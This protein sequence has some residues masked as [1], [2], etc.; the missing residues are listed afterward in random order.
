MDDFTTAI[1]VLLGLFSGMFV[2]LP[3]MIKLSNFLDKPE[4]PQTYEEFLYLRDVLE[5]LLDRKE[6]SF[7]FSYYGYNPKEGFYRRSIL[8]TPDSVYEKELLT[9]NQLVTIL[10]K[11]YRKR[12][13]NKV[14][15]MS[16]T[17]LSERISVMN[18][19]LETL[20][21]TKGIS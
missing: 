16:T 1:F 6:V 11:S 20:K 12:N 17:T 5:Y 13:K 21:Q 8:Y 4:V 9:Y 18:E 7:D 2:F 10:L 14:S 3:L 15:V 19:I